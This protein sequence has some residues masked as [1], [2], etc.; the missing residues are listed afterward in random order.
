M[1]LATIEWG[2]V[3]GSSFRRRKGIAAG[4]NDGLIRLSVGVEDAE[5]LLADVERA[6]STLR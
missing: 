4:L 5:D 3:S 1:S 2:R 6:L